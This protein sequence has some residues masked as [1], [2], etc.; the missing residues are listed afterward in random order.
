MDQFTSLKGNVKFIG[1]C[2]RAYSGKTTSSAF[3]RQTVSGAVV[4]P[5]A[6]RLKEIAKDVF[7]W[8]GQKDARGRRLLQLLGT[9][10]AR[11]YNP[12]FWVTAWKEEVVRTSN[13]VYLLSGTFPRLI[14]ADDVR[15]DNEAE[16]IK[17]MGGTIVQIARPPVPVAFSDHAS[18]RGISPSLIDMTVDNCE[19]LPSLYRSVQKLVSTLG[20][21]SLVKGK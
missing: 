11:G 12:D 5:F 8:D 14:M 18:E 17:Q 15:F 2:G 19:D 7:G 20:L 13:G 3:A 21:Y 10:V 4:I 6:Q 1:F 16:A 9:E